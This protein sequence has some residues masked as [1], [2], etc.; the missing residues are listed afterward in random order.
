MTIEFFNLTLFI[1]GSGSTVTV[2][3]GVVVAVVVSFVVVAVVIVVVVVLV[4]RRS[5]RR[6][7]STT[8]L[9]LSF[10]NYSHLQVIV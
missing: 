2:H 4:M 8:N 3:I 1:G 9:T 5:R 7:A 10:V 6:L